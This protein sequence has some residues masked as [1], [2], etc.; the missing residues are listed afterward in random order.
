MPNLLHHVAIIRKSG[1]DPVVCLNR[2]FSDTEEEIKFFRRT[3]KSYGI[4]CAVSN[5]WARGGEGATEFAEKVVSATERK[6]AFKFLYPRSQKI[7]SKIKTIATQIYGAK[8][9]KFSSK[10][11]AR[12]SQLE[13]NRAFEDFELVMVKTPLSLSDDHTKKGVPTEWTLFVN[14]VLVFTGARFIC[15]VAGDINLM[16]GTSSSPAFRNID[17]E[18]EAQRVTGII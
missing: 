15:P 13:S 4:S 3:L 18:V 12:L 2:F 9:V 6:S 14:D 17:V 16:P 8:G 7:R 10:A 5:H 1:L 11:L